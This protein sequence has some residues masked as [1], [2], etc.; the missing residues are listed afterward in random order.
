MSRRTVRRIILWLILGL[1]IL[2][3]GT[4]VLVA[5]PPSASGTDSVETVVAQTADAAQTQT[6]R[7]LPPSLTPSLTPAAT[8]TATVTPTPTATILF[9]FPTNT[10]L[11][12]SFFEDTVGG[13]TGDDSSDGDSED[14]DG[15]IR[16]QDL[17]A[18]R[19]LSK[20]PA[21]EMV[22]I[23][24]TSFK[25][26][27]TVQNTGSETWPKK[28]VDIVYVSGTRLNE[29][30]PYYDIPRAVAPGGTVTISVTMNFPKR[31]KDYQTRWGLKIGRTEF[32]TVKFEFT[33]K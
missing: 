13:G 18:C 8:K 21:D 14:E 1:V 19:V 26:T 5:P 11:P 10:S 12:A 20:N 17:W 33:V 7:A 2:S 3:C 29:G 32:C 22:V 24:G 30:K 15:R 16:T 28:S 6:M 27:W 4:P 25:T 9:L 31:Q 23:G